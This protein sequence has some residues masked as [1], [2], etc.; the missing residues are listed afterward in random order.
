M[1]DLPAPTVSEVLSE[2]DEWES[3]REA[4]NRREDTPGVYVDPDEWHNSDDLA[5]Y[6][7][8][9]LTNAV[10]Q[11]QAS[12]NVPAGE[13]VFTVTIVG[14]EEDDGEAPYLYVVHAETRQG[15]CAVAELAHRAGQNP[16]VE[17]RRVT[18]ERGL[19]RAGV[20]FNDLRGA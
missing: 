7:L 5:V 19:P 12:S 8:R 1:T 6:L 18:V 16:G 9:E 10:R 15:A 11:Q 20:R 2:Y 4:L 17:V 13:E 14:P 3:E